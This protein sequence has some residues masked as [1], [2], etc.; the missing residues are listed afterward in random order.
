[1]TDDT[2]SFE[3]KMCIARNE[4]VKSRLNGMDL[5]IDVRAQEMERRLEGLNELRQDVVKDRDLFVRKDVFYQHQDSQ[6]KQYEEIEKRVGMHDTRITII[7]TR[8]VV[9]T[10]AIAMFFT[11]VQ[12]LMRLWK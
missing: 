10:A 6:N 9:W 8:A 3:E 1:M 7:E 5:A 11:V 4:A 2:M 12:V